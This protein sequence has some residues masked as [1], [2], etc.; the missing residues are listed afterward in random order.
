MNSMAI[1]RVYQIKE[2][3]HGQDKL[4]RNNQRKFNTR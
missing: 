4:I 2:T 1:F 3:H